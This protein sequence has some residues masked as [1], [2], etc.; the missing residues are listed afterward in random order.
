VESVRW[1][2]GECTRAVL[3]RAGGGRAAR[4][5]LTENGDRTV[6]IPSDPRAELERWDGS[7][8]TGS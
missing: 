1:G 6:F 7:L 2:G 8:A 4:L 5:L 3:R